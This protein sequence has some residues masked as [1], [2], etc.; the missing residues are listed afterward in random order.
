MSGKFEMSIIGEL[1]ILLGLQINQ[2]KDSTS[3]YQQKFIK[4]LLKKFDTDGVLLLLLP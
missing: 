3:I 4:E 2:T 1:T